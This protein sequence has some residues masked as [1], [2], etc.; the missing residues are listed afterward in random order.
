MAEGTSVEEGGV[1]HDLREGIIGMLVGVGG[2]GSERLHLGG[3][4]N[5]TDQVRPVVGAPVLDR[6]PEVG[7]PH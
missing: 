4:V 5:P 6:Q 3:G 2:E 1:F 7:A